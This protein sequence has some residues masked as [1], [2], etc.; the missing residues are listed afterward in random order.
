MRSTTSWTSRAPRRTSRVISRSR[1]WAA[2]TCRCPAPSRSSSCS[3]ARR[4]LPRPLP[5]WNA[6]GTCSPARRTGWS[7]RRAGA[8]SP[9]WQAAA[10]G[11]RARRLAHRARRTRGSERP[12]VVL[13]PPLARSAGALAHAGRARRARARRPLW[14]APLPHLERARAGARDLPRSGAGA[15]RART[16]HPGV[17][18]RRRAL[19]RSGLRA[20]A[21]RTLAA[22]LPGSRGA[23]SRRLARRAGPSRETSDEE[24]R[25]LLVRALDALERLDAFQSELRGARSD[26]LREPSSFALVPVG[27]AEALR[28]LGDG[29]CRPEQGGRLLGFLADAHPGW[30]TAA[31]SAWCSRPSSEVA[32]GRASR[33]WMRACSVRASRG[34]SASCRLPRPISRRPTRAASRCPPRSRR[35]VLPARTGSTR[36]S[37]VRSC[38]RGLRP[39]RSSRSRWGA[40]RAAADR[41]SWNSGGASLWRETLVAAGTRTRSRSRTASPGPLFEVPTADPSADP[42]PLPGARG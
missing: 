10:R 16:A 34:C 17:E 7:S 38:S 39:A 19:R 37:A 9:C 21:R 35:T 13:G 36:A 31:V 32:R 41:A 33:R 28:I 30:P 29:E 15:R 26:L 18:R 27:L 2:R 23:Q 20:R 5:H 14:A 4:T 6:S 8:C 42:R 25:A 3:R 11:R 12:P 22:R 40:R 24:L 1:I